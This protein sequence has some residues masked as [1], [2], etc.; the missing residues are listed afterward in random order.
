M[1]SIIK[2]IIGGMGLLS[3]TSCSDFLDQSSPSEIKGDMVFN[4]LTFTEQSLN[5]VYAGLTLDHTYGARIPL[6]FGFNT[7]IELV[8]ADVNKLASFTESSERALGN[9]NGE[10]ISGSWSKLDDNWKNCFAIIED[11]N[12]VVE[13]IRSSELFQ[14]GNPARNKMANFLGE[15]LTIRAMV[16]FDLV[17]NYGDLPMKFETTK[18]DGSNLYVAKSDRDDI[19]EQLLSDLEEA[20]NYLPWAGESGY[21]T[22]HATAGFAHGLFARIALAKAGYSI[23]ESSKPGYE[24][25]AGSDGT[26]PTQRPGEAERKLLYERALKHL[27]AVIGSGVHKL[28]PSYADQ[29]F[30]VNQRKLDNT[31]K[32]NLYEVAHGL[33][34]SGEMGYTI[35]VR[36]SGAS[37][38]YGAKGNSSG[39]VKLTAPFFWSFDHSDLRRDITCATYELKEENG[40]IKENMQKN[41][42]FGIYVA[43]WDIRKMNDEW[44][45]AVRASDAK[46][47]YGINWI[48]MRYSDILLMY[49]EVMNELYGA[50]AANPLGGTA[51]TARTALTEVH[52]RAF[53]N[54]ANAQAYVA[55]ISSGDDF[56]NAIVDERA[57]EFAGECVRKY[58]LIRWGLLSKK[59]DQFKEDYRQ[60]TTIAPKYIFYKM[61]ADDEYS[62][63]MSSICWYEY[64]SFVSE[65][66]NELD[67]KN[68]IKNAADPNWKYVPG[69][70]T[71]PNGKIEKDT[72]TKQEV[73]KEDG[74]TSNDSNL[75][76]LTDYVST[77]LDKTVKNRHL[78]P[79]GSKTIS[80]SNG[81]LANSYG[82]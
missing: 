64:P 25:L 80:E 4:S 67:V 73:F 58:D 9:Y 68:A 7:D 49:A 75:S 37:S 82:F 27:T 12:L 13:G 59:I 53:D 3:I 63:D 65:I 72:T 28:N 19:M 78:I 1:K 18:V 20:A 8:D 36:I 79:L 16:Y 74:S 22:E 61:K 21:T 45:N 39:K 23:R 15:A 54:K 26:Y 70:G 14:E 47:G 2:Y 10:S 56:F 52:S 5:K 30:Q 60:L 50:D 41:A 57:W 6:N 31:Y 33:N 17:K 34:K 51:M 55:T 42:P 62:I 32:E 24:T 29:W 77:G 38:Y 76:G 71:F 66:N 48:A 40:H 46:I 11:A 44:L 35:G 43:K 69:W 81:T